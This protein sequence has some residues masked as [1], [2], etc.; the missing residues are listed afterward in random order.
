MSV[1]DFV[2]VGARRWCLGC[3][4][5]QHASRVGW[6]PTTGEVCAET[7]PYARK[8][9]PLRRLLAMSRYEALARF[10]G[11]YKRRYNLADARFALL[12][13]SRP[14]IGRQIHLNYEALR[15]GRTQ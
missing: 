2:T 9:R 10:R 1:H 8:D 6:V 5:F 15:R 14:H 13:N 11:E 7:T 12:I 3:D 4:L